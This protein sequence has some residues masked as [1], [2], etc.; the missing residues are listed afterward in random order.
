MKYIFSLLLLIFSF[1]YKGQQKAIT[2]VQNPKVGLSLSGGGAKGFA[3]I[4][5]IKVLDSLGVNIDYVAGTSMGAI[6]GGLYASGYSGKEMEKI[7]DQTDVGVIL[8]NDKQ[9]SEE[10]FFNKSNQ[11][12]FINFPIKNGKIKLPSSLSNGQKTIYFLNEIFKDVRHFKDFSKLPIPFMCIATNLETGKEKV[13]EEGELTDA[14]MASAAFPSL[15]DAVKINDSLYIDGGVSINYP[16]ELL[17]KKGI[18]IVIGI[19]LDQGL[20]KAKNLDNFIKILGQIINYGIEKNYRE[21]EKFTDIDIKPN[22]KGKGITSF[23]DKK[24][25]IDSGFSKTL[26]YIQL[27]NQLPKTSFVK[28]K[29]QYNRNP[30]LENVYKID[31]IEVD[32]A[33]RF[34]ISYIKGKMGLKT[35]SIISYGQISK[36]IDK[37][38]S[39]DNYQLI[40][41]EIKQVEED[42]I[43]LLSVEENKVYNFFKV[44][45]HYDKV[46]SNGLL[47][48]YSSRKFLFH[49]SNLSLDVVVGNK[50]RYFFNYFIDNGYIPGFGINSSGYS[51]EFLNKKNKNLKE[52]WKIFRNEVYLESVLNEVVAFGGGLSYDYIEKNDFNIAIIKNKY[53][54]PYFFIKSDTQ[55]NISFPTKGILFNAEAKFYNF[56]AA[57]DAERGFQ[58]KAN[59]HINYALNKRLTLQSNNFAGITVDKVADTYQYRLGGFQKQ[60]ILNFYRYLGEEIG[61]ITSNN[62][63]SSHNA[64]QIRI[65]KNYYLIPNIQIMSTFDEFIDFG[66]FKFNYKTIGLSAAYNSPVGE[67]KVNYSK[68]LGLQKGIFN[69]TFGYWF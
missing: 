45:L 4:G 24:A 22:L 9:R 16:S 27:L 18:D 17:K 60:N 12:Y 32:G 28:I 55:D 62:V 54:N 51:F 49:N 56:Y 29:Q 31:R 39:S 7:L 8:Q 37:L 42:N 3:H 33:N 14:I 57:K 58:V 44:G 67:I 36:M 35:P 68:S 2:F 41:Y 21:Q 13:F 69:F 11:K 26:E 61:Q 66:V 43:L 30:I 23:D 52:E 5:V 1:L 63:F 38:Y 20:E 65:L 64:L 6:I 53:F 15:L 40:R 50:P 47:L 59:F 19:N 48:N 25:I 34:D 10:S 46:F